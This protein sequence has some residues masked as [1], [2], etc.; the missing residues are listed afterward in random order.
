MIAT[1]AWPTWHQGRTREYKE[2]IML[3]LSRKKGESIVIL[4][5]IIVT[6]VDLRNGK[7]RLGIEAPREVAVHRKELYDKINSREEAPSPT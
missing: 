1:R 5:D 3:V 7:V 6:V 4:D 2:G